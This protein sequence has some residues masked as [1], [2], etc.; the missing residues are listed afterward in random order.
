MSRLP[1]PAPCPADL[2]PAVA[3]ALAR[4]DPA[5]GLA[6][7]QGLP[8]GRS[9]RVWRVGDLV[10][11]CHD[12]AAATPL[13]PNDAGM[14]ARALRRF[15]PQGLAPR[16]RAAGKGWIIYDHLPGRIG[17][18]DPA[19]VAAMLHR[20]HSLPRSGG[21]PFRLLPNGSAALLS[22]ARG[23]APPGLP[24][25]PADP[26]IPPVP[27]RPVHADAV[28]GNILTTP[29][30]PLLIDWQCPGLGDPVEDLATLLSPAMMWLY[31]GGKA[32]DGW[33]EA[34][35]HHYPDRATADRT[36]ALL[37]LYRW[38]IAAHCA[39]RAARGDAAYARALRIELETP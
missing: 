22:H 36:R 14:E 1:P 4:L 37:P 2:P 27:P 20:L 29:A 19:A 17:P 23:F 15:G 31:T 38:R 39:L 10:V 26:R 5:C 30:G 25:P 24:P 11:K 33:A 9:N 21:A 18:G 16:L 12:P 6:A 3:R 7:W 32:P 28:P 35:L 34:L 8:G 13:F